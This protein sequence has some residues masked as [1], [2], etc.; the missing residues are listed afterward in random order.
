VTDLFQRR[1]GLLYG[2]A[3][4]LY[5][6]VFL[7]VFIAYE[8]LPAYEPASAPA[9]HT[10]AIIIFALVLVGWMLARRD[11]PLSR[12]ALRALE[13]GFVLATGPH[14]GVQTYLNAD[15]L[16]PP[17]LLFIYT[18]FAVMARAVLVPSTAR[19][20]IVLSG[21]CLAGWGIPSVVAVLQGIPRAP[22]FPPV[23]VIPFIVVLC[24]AMT[25]LAG[26]ASFV[27]DRLQRRL[28][29]VQRAGAYQLGRKLGEGANGDVFEARHAAHRRRLAVK[30]IPDVE[31]DDAARLERVLSVTSQLDHPGAAAIYDY[32][33]AVDGSF[34]C[35]MELIDGIDLET[36]VREHGPLPVG[37]VVPILVQICAVLDS[38]HA[39]DVV[40][41][42]L[43]PANVLLTRHGL[44]TEGIKIVD[45]GL[46]EPVNPDSQLTSPELV[47]GTPGYLAP[48]AITDPH[49]VGP[50]SDAYSLGAVAYFLVTGRTV[51]DGETVAEMC[52]QHIHTE[53]KPPS[54][55]V[56]A[57]IPP[58]LDELILACLAKKPDER[59][60]S[61]GELRKKLEAVTASDWSADQ[62]AAW[63]DELEASR[64]PATYSS[65]FSRYKALVPA[66]PSA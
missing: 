12:A 57:N 61:P 62:A 37:R 55:R 5:A 50:Q 7:G 30:V 13:W 24:V 29:D 10:I 43:K 15:R 11:R 51:F 56:S 32:G 47:A 1:L 21:V 46:V 27:I 14:F 38:A 65:S 9:Q 39:R 34:F 49:D 48:E 22:E 66:G 41:R 17:L 33:R 36:L 45:F 16:T 40:H 26:G 4:W 31:P 25:S 42:D 28:S 8:N 58:E 59:P 3:F 23:M 64:D 35:T 20:T 19:R 53:P 54:A 6:C 18:A 52:A 60:Q 44:A 63:W 2:L